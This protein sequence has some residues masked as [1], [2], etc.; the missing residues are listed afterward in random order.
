MTI[1]I[2]IIILCTNKTFC[3]MLCKFTNCNTSTFCLTFFHFHLCSS[4][5]YTSSTKQFHVQSFLLP[6][7]HSFTQTTSNIISLSWLLLY[8]KT[9]WLS[10][11][12][13]CVSVDS[14]SL[15]STMC[16]ACCLP[17]YCRAT[18]DLSFFSSLLFYSCTLVGRNS[19]SNNT[20]PIHH[21][22]LFDDH[23]IVIIFFA[24]SHCTK[25]CLFLLHTY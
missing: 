23:N 24:R 4:V 22:R 7:S 21:A 17:A 8:R 3:N 9:V 14:D 18:A 11:C 15:F 25:P 2:L 20:K 19:S 16:V 10:W 13:K 12:V 5:F 1:I 6:E